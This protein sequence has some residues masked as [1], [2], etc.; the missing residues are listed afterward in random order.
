MRHQDGRG[1]A[2]RRTPSTRVLLDFEQS[3]K[4][5][6]QPRRMCPSDQLVATSTS[7]CAGFLRCSVH[8]RAHGNMLLGK[9][10]GGPPTPRVRRPRPLEGKLPLPNPGCSGSPSITENQ[11]KRRHQSASRRQP[12]GSAGTSWLARG[13]LGTCPRRARPDDPAAR[14]QGSPEA[15]R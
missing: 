3:V 5:E 9:A 7:I 15:A 2:R 10:R 12:R 6:G 14:A 1:T 11:P 4:R 13:T 8:T